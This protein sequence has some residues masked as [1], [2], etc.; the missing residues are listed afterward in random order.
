MLQVRKSLLNDDDNPSVIFNLNVSYWYY[1]VTREMFYSEYFG[2]YYLLKVFV[3]IY[4][5][6]NSPFMML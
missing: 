6:N 1:N 5:S 4:I 3:V 2:N